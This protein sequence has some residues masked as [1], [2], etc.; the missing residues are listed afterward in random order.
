MAPRQR[1]NISTSSTPTLSEDESCSN[2]VAATSL[3]KEQKSDASKAKPAQTSSITEADIARDNHDYFNIVALA[4]VVYTCA[5]N[6]E[7]PSLSYT[8]DHFWTMWAATIIYFIMDLSWVTIVPTCV[9]SPGVIVK[10]HIVAMIYL[11][12]PIYYPRYRWLMG[13]VLSVE[14]NTWFLIARRLVYRNNYCP[15]GYA[16][17]SPIITSTVSAFFYFTW[18]AIR[19][20]LYPSVL[21]LFFH[22][23][24][25][26]IE[27]TG[28]VFFWELL[29][30][31]VHFVLCV[32]NLKW[33]YDLFKPIVKRW[34]G[35]GPKSIAVQNGFEQSARKKVA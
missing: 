20:Y 9:K 4:V 19:C 17:V 22:L 27:L 33:T 16:K 2:D 24:K 29:F 13:A 7:Y 8:G 1:N 31:P 10:H 12:A 11:L 25:E 35:I 15:S 26:E 3:L 18:L 14:L 21:L 32:L 30:I 5:L 34:V 23:W 28:R 6:Y